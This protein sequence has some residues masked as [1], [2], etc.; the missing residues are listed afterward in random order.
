[1]KKTLLSL[2]FILIF[3]LRTF[4]DGL[5]LPV[6]KDYPMDFLKNLVSKVDVSI[7]GMVAETK[8]YQEFRNDW[9]Q[10]TDAM[11]SFP[12]PSDAR[13]TDITYWKN[14]IAYKAVL[15]V[16][17]QD[18]NP[19]TGESPLVAAVNRYMGSNAIRILLKNIA[20]NEIQRIQ[21]TYISLLDYYNGD[22]TY[23][24]PLNTSP[25]VTHSIEQLDIH[26]SVKSNRPVQTADLP[27]HP[28][29]KVTLHNE[30]EFE[31]TYSEPKAWLTRDVEMVFQES[32]SGLTF[33]LYSK[34]SPDQTGWYNLIITP[35]N[36]SNPDS[37]FQKRMV[38]LVNISSGMTADQIQK[39]KEG[40]S[41]CLDYLRPGD[42]FNIIAYNSG[43]TKWKTSLQA[44]SATTVE[45]AKSFISQLSVSGGSRLDAAL[46]E[47]L[48]QF[49]DTLQQNSVLN[50]TNGK[51][52]VDPKVIQTLNTKKA[53][54]FSIAFGDLVD[55]ERL[56]YLSALNY[57]FVRYFRESDNL[58][59][60]IEKVFRMVSDPIMA[61]IRVTS[62]KSDLSGL[63]AVKGTSIYSNAFTSVSGTYSTPGDAVVTL[64]GRNKMQ[65]QVQY[66][67]SSTF[68]PD[69]LQFGFVPS[70]WAKGKID[71]L[72][73][74]ILVDGET[75]T[76]KDSLIALSLTYGIRC[77][78]TAYIADYKTVNTGTG[79]D[80]E[81]PAFAGVKDNYPNPFN[82]STTIRIYISREM[83][84]KINL[85]KIYSITGQLVAVIDI[86]GFKAGW[87][88]VLFYAAGFDG[89]ALASGV[90]FVRLTSGNELVNTIRITLIR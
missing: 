30:S 2:T 52:L 64:S 69:T 88:E 63:S 26:F 72:E 12:L 85:L 48:K 45:S 21:L 53:G 61:G 38:F 84:G 18:T 47:A 20:P 19:G 73:Q 10:T 67:F 44:S 51:S 62:A 65:K 15:E 22:C 89:R 4:A 41:S 83:E 80:P 75:Q 25:F 81:V 55:R 68:S 29:A 71:A 46:P 37:L 7:T 76:L 42:Q 11:Y 60:G 13:A 86:T 77:R 74:V 70:L 36:P 34:Y 28:G 14:D 56:E 54:I 50:F 3:S 8:I 49:T 1:M 6:H 31:L 90:Y 57:G 40:L 66:P 17:R 87:N 27:S 58:K 33:N 43:I 32:A 79:D 16:R 35:P 23:R 5:L 24:F 39:S 78:Y 9:N 59:A 82:P